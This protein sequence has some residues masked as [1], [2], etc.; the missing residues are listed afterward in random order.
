[1]YTLPEALVLPENRVG[2]ETRALAEHAAGEPAVRVPAAL[3][4]PPD[5]EE[6]FYRSNNLPA[7]LA[8][9]FRG[10]RPSRIDED[11][12]EPLCE[13]AQTLLR[14]CALLDD[15]V[16]HFY[17]ALNRAGLGSGPLHLRRPGT[18]HAEV[19]QVRPPGA[20]ALFALKRLWAHDWSFG[21]VLARL[22]EEGGVGLEARPTVLLRG[23]PGQPDAALAA[24]L[25]VRRAWVSA[26]GLVG[27][28]R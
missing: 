4:V 6:D 19:A 18:R 8:E 24:Q 9:L 23:E 13:R 3:I 15:S 27:L 11:A 26:H 21:S 2:A 25:G 7:Q 12:L 1:M 20:E 14:G 16:Q 10:I 5:F 17:R 22:D 28:T